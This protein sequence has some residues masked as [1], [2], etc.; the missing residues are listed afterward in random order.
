MSRDFLFGV[1]VGVA[2]PIVWHKFVKPI[3]GKGQ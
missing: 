2:V 1:A 3:K